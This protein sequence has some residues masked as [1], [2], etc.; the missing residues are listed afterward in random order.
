MVKTLHP[1]GLA[2]VE[3]LIR[4]RINLPTNQRK[5]EEFGLQPIDLVI[6]K[7]KLAAKYND[8]DLKRKKQLLVLLGGQ[9]HE[10][11]KTYIEKL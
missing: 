9:F 7:N 2:K 5:L 1:N 8:L 3:H 6:N 11:V 4:S 10:N